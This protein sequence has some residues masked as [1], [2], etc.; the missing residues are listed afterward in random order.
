MD[1]DRNV[2]QFADN[3]AALR[4]YRVLHS[5]YGAHS[6][7]G[8]SMEADKVTVTGGAEVLHDV[9]APLAENMGGRKCR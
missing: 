5:E 2:F 8:A 6:W 3:P 1:I 4:F 7:I 9:V